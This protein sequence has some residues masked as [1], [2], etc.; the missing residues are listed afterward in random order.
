MEL[1]F[2]SYQF[3]AIYFCSFS[4]KKVFYRGIFLNS[5]K[6][7]VVKESITDNPVALIQP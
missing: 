7:K 4:N 2:K 5:S 1:K 6:K 3:L